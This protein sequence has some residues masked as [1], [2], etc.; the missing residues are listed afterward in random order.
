MGKVPISH[1]P[2]IWDRYLYLI[3]PA[4]GIKVPKYH[5]ASIWDRYL[6]LIRAA[7]GIDTYIS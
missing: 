5:K 6:Y 7:Y 2:S 4:Y 3:R 1:K